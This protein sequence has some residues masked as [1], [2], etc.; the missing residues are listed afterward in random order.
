MTI[1]RLVSLNKKNFNTKR[2]KLVFMLVVPIILVLGLV[3]SGVATYLE[4][5]HGNGWGVFEVAQFS[6]VDVLVS[7]LIICASLANL[8]RLQ[9]SQKTASVQ[10]INR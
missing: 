10:N 6:I 1:V 5:A 2:E 7:L 8:R 9:K 3:C 4:V